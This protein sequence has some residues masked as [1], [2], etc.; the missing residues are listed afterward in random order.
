MATVTLGFAALL[1][2][3]VAATVADVARAGGIVAEVGGG[4]ATLVDVAWLG[5]VGWAA[6]IAALVLHARARRLDAA[7]AA[8]IGGAVVAVAGGVLELGD[9]A[10]S[11]RPS[12]LPLPLARATVVAALGL[13]GA[14][15]VG[16]AARV[17][18][19][20]TR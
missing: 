8:A 11:Q 1:V 16:G 13:G 15:A 9:V 18:R 14:A 6:A 17:L 7:V 3:A 2:A 4:F 5:A 12:A 10:T 20:P 19:P